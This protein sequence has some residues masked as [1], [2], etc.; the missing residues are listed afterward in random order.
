MPFLPSWTSWSN[1]G[2]DIK[3]VITV[4]GVRATGR[5]RSGAAGTQKNYTTQLWSLRRLPGGSDI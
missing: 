5:V 4:Q 3:Q 1:G 2:K